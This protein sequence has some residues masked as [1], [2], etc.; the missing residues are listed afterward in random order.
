MMTSN[1]QSTVKR[2]CCQTNC[3]W[4]YRYVA[5]FEL[6]TLNQAKTYNVLLLK[7]YGD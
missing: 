3:Q 1:K 6:C 2:H 7:I 5:T 4:N